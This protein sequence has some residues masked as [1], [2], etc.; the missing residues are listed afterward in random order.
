MGGTLSGSCPVEVFGNY[1]P[2]EI[3]NSATYTF[4][5]STLFALGNAKVN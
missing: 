1:L 2:A 3:C 5:V 4:S